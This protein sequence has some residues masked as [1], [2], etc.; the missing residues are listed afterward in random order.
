MHLS[1][2]Q[3]QQ[4]IRMHNNLGHPDATVLRHV[5]KDQQWPPEAVERIKDLHCSSCCERQKPRLARPSH[6]GRH[7]HFNDLVAMDAVTWTNAQGQSFLFYHIIDTSTN[8]HVAI[9]CEHRPNSE[10][11]S[12]LFTK[13][14]IN[15]AGPPKMLLHDSAG[16]FAVKN[17]PGI[18]KGTIFEAA[19]SPQK[20]TGSLAAVKDMARCFNLCWINGRYNIP[21]VVFQSLK[22]L[23]PKISLPKIACPAGIQP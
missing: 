15:W 14:W 21:S 17:W 16:D 4:L 11:L 12:P 1:A 18:C 3:R 20:L 23:F 2:E 6:L 7:R 9:P 10:T 5:L 19:R 22:W 13:H 8:F